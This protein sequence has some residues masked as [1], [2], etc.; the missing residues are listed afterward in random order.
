MDHLQNESQSVTRL[1][2]SVISKVNVNSFGSNSY[3]KLYLWA[4]CN[5]GYTLYLELIYSAY[6]D[7]RHNAQHYLTNFCPS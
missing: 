1:T 3:G 5:Y 7:K 6:H 2:R 4:I